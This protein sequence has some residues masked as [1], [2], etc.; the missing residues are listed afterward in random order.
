MLNN[1][2]S[3]LHIHFDNLTLPFL[4]PFTTAQTQP[5]DC[6]VFAVMKNEYSKW[7]IHETLVRVPEH[8][9]LESCVS[10]FDTIFKDLDIRIINNS[11]KKT[12]LSLFRSKPT[13]TT[14]LTKGEQVMNLIERMDKFQCSD[15][16]DD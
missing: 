3:H 14:E 11:F 6:S 4:P 16:E 15:S 1:V 7:L 5:L 10:A 8:I 13:I 12:K 9:K 2:P